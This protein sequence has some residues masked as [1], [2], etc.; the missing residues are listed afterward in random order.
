MKSASNL[1][2][3]PSIDE[4]PEGL[5]PFQTR[6][7]YFSAWVS[8]RARTVKSKM[9]FTVG[10]WF[11]AWLMRM[12]F[13]SHNM[14]LLIKQYDGMR[15]RIQVDEAQIIVL[16][17]EDGANEIEETKSHISRRRR[18]I[19]LPEMPEETPL[20]ERIDQQYKRFLATQR[21]FWF[22]R[23]CELTVESFSE[24]VQKCLPEVPNSETHNIF[25]KIRYTPEDHSEHDLYIDLKSGCFDLVTIDKEYKD[26]RFMF[27]RFTLPSSEKVEKMINA[28]GDSEL[29][30]IAG[31][32]LNDL[33]YAFDA[34]DGDSYLDQLVS[35]MSD[36]DDSDVNNEIIDFVVDDKCAVEIN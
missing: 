11:P 29:S 28:P 4:P 9:N 20:D 21:L 18:I 25:V 35:E 32:C 5:S 17:I 3:E 27:G 22:M 7:W 15:H 1:D 13:R 36:S 30:E 8:S 24:F 33:E 10:I 16:P 31:G 2:D 19:K 26:K 6:L 23:K 34:C 12:M 14:P